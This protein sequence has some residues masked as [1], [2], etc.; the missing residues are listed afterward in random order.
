MILPIP[1]KSA[2]HANPGAAAVENPPLG[3]AITLIAGYVY[4]TRARG[5]LEHEN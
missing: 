5:H 4:S 3:F 2:I 1:I